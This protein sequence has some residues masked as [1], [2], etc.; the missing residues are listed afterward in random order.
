MRVL[1][2]E[3]AYRFVKQAISKARLFKSSAART[4]VMDLEDNSEPGLV[5]VDFCDFLAKL[6]EKSFK[7]GVSLHDALP[8]TVIVNATSD[9]LA[10]E[11][12]RLLAM[13]I[14]FNDGYEH[15]E[16]SHAMFSE[17][18]VINRAK[19]NGKATDKLGRS[20]YFLRL[21]TFASIAPHL[22]SV[23]LGDTLLCTSDSDVQLKV[24][25]YCGT[26]ANIGSQWSRGQILSLF[27]T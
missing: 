24:S 7:A 14:R 1:G 4:I 25:K 22:A 8:W 20:S 16:F 3:K 10:A 5:Q 9:R 12:R 23:T 11:K 17:P 27:S 19:R 15:I 6:T 13:G 21:V 2:P 18:P 26:R